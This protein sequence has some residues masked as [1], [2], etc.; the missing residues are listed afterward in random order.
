MK[1]FKLSGMFKNEFNRIY[2][3]INGTCFFSEIWF[4]GTPRFI[5]WKIK[6]L[7]INI[8][9]KDGTFLYFS[10]LLSFSGKSICALNEIIDVMGMKKVHMMSFCPTRMVYLLTTAAHSVK[11][12]V[13]LCNVL[14]TLDV[15]KEQR[16]VFLTPKS[17]FVLHALAD[18]EE[19]F[20]KQFLKALDTNQSIAIDL[21]K[22][23]STFARSLGTIVDV[24]LSP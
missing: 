19:P 4:K 13:P 20:Q 15:K 12:L 17:M 21:Y 23:N 5:K 10:F 6:F 24:I 22:L 16:D 18:L 9:S 7:K 14:V 2:F 3:I 1:H 11:L 8:T